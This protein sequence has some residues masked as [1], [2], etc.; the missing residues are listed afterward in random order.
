MSVIIR[1]T[2]SANPQIILFIK[3]ADSVIF[4]RLSNDG[5][6]YEKETIEHLENY[7]SAGLRTLTCAYRIIEPEVYSQWHSKFAAAR[8]AL[9]GRDEK[10]AQVADEIEQELVLLG[11]TAIE[12]KLQE[13]VPSAIS[14]LGDAGI[15][16]WILTGDKQETAINVGYAC[17]LIK[18][19]MGLH[20]LS[21]KFHS[22]MEV[23]DQVESKMRRLDCTISIVIDSV[24]LAIRFLITLSVLL[25]GF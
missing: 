12:D 15:R 8:T 11:A 7:G 5:R 18:E 17:W 13:G 10:V 25:A 3:G 9:S 23:D 6:K 20:D 2:K 24:C 19:G 22:G 16:V 21:L 4:S 1:E 14:A